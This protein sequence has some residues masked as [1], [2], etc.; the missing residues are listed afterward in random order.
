MQD[1]PRLS[2]IPALDG[3][4]ALSVIAV[5]LFHAQAGFAPGGFL[6]VSVF[7]T[8]SG[9]LITSLLLT[10]FDS[11]HTIALGQ[12]YGRRLRRLTPAS[13]SC[14]ALVLSL[15]LIWTSYQREHLRGDVLA[16]LTNMSNWRFAFASTSY[17]DIFLGSPSPLAHYWSLAIEEQCY[18]VLP[19]IV[20]VALRRSRR[21]LLVT[22]CT[23]LMCSIFATMVTKSFNVVYNGTHTRGAELL[24]GVLLAQLSFDGERR[25]KVVLKA[26]PVAL[27]LLGLLGVSTSLSDHWIYRGGLVA[28]ALLSALA[29][30]SLVLGGHCSRFLGS[31]PLVRIGRISYGLYL[32]H[33]PLFVFLSPARTH[34]HGLA[35]ASLRIV[36]SVAA[37]MATYHL[38]EL[39]I[40]QRHLLT[41]PRR[42]FAAMALASSALLV[43]AVV[44]VPRPTFSISAQMLADGSAGPISF[45]PDGHSNRLV[46][47]DGRSVALHKRVLV[48]GSDSTPLDVLTRNGYDTIDDVEPGCPLVPIPQSLTADGGSNDPSRCDNSS[49]RWTG[50]IESSHPDLIVISTGSTER[51]PPASGTDGANGVLAMQLA[52]VGTL[53]AAA[54]AQ[55]DS[56][57]NALDRSGIPYV[58]VDHRTASDSALEPLARAGLMHPNAGEAV[59]T[60]EQLTA[61]VRDRLHGAAASDGR[62]DVVVVGDSTSLFLARALND[63]GQ[64]KLRVTWAGENGCPFVPVEALRSSRRPDGTW[65]STCANLRTTLPPILDSVQPDVVLLVDT[66]YELAEQRY[67]GDPVWHVP[68]DAAYQVFHDAA[69]SSFEAMLR[70]KG[71]PLLIADSPGARVGPWFTAEMGAPARL[72][73]WNTQIRRWC[74]SSPYIGNFR[75]AEPLLDAEARHRLTR[76]DGV[77]PEI[78]PLTDLARSVYVDELIKQT[79]ELRASLGLEPHRR[80]DR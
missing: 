8:I 14:V 56:A 55:L 70:E 42:A 25:R 71:I 54:Y 66:V 52:D 38:F 33:W 59:T 24:V 35:L 22:T 28:I 53:L 12:F 17:R 23:L 32:I 7:F 48:L 19:I 10:E 64:T 2:Y 77:H 75:Y 16:A 29:I 5:L 30:A 47:S 50:L 49:T 45:G 9:Y 3:L 18:L 76:A 6:G 44:G 40:R 31:K 73:A 67:P 20:W 79:H 57:F 51:R 11:T 39:R 21:A 72:D 34:V 4:R 78:E 74:D 68:G 60:N 15:G 27:V 41:T 1:A 26:G 65:I 58:I 80:A 62:L 46:P 63:A 61:T 37:A 13:Y 43:A 36:T 69:M